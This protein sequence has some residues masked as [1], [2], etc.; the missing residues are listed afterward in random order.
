MRIDSE[1]ERLIEEA[2]KFHEY[3]AKEDLVTAALKEYIQHCKDLKDD[4][5]PRERKLRTPPRRR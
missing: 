5:P 1:T 4:S 3:G 2:M